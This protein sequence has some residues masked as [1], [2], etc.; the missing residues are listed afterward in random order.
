MYKAV[1]IAG[2]RCGIKELGNFYVAFKPINLFLI[3]RGAV[4]NESGH[5]EKRKNR[6]IVLDLGELPMLRPVT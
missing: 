6:G 1:S 2:V 4:R 5:K 3:L